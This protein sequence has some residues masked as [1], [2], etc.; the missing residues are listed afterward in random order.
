M[1]QRP[2]NYTAYSIATAV[3]WGVV[4]VL[5]RLI[6]PASTLHTFWLVSLGF[7]LGW[8]SAT[9]ARAVYPPPGQHGSRPAPASQPSRLR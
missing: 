1:P 3:V 4:L 8:L 6:D 7:F 9:I 2:R 5:V